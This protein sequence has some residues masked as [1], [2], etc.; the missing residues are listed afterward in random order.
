[1]NSMSEV[2]SED[3]W[4]FGLLRS[5][6]GFLGKC[7]STQSSAPSGRLRDTSGISRQN[8]EIIRRL[9]DGFNRRDASAMADLWTA[10]GEWSPAYIGGGLL[11]GAVFRGHEGLAEFIEMQSATGRASSPSPWRYRISTIR[12]SWRCASRSSVAQAASRLSGSLGTFSRSATERP[13]PGRVYL[14][15]GEVLEAAGTAQ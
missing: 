14:S 12:C 8:I 15:K 13:R 3:S 10:D 4:R 1:M 9:F 2:D 6:A 7:C 11:E 5:F